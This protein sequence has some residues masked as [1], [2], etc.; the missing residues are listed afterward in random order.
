MF[1][2][3]SQAFIYML[4]YLYKQ[5]V[6]KIHLFT[7]YPTIFTKKII[8]FIFLLKFYPFPLLFLNNFII[9]A[10]IIF[11]K[12]KNTTTLWQ[13]KKQSKNLTKW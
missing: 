3:L 11:L 4:K 9:F 8:F 12:T 1:F 2:N 5:S 13:K 10:I 6:A 7:D